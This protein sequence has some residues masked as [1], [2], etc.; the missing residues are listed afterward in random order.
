MLLSQLTFISK[1]ENFLLSS[2]FTY[3]SAVEYE[4]R[5]HNKRML[6]LSGLQLS[7]GKNLFWQE[8]HL[9]NRR[10]CISQSTKQNYCK[11]K[12]KQEHHTLH[13]ALGDLGFSKKMLLSRANREFSIE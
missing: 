2:T 13:T 4:V 3:K 7:A 11:D 1:V 5:I 9:C 6:P 8:T 10:K 12:Y